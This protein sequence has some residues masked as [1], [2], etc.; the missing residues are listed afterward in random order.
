VLYRKSRGVVRSANALEKLLN[1]QLLEYD[2]QGI[3]LTNAGQAVRLRAL[4]ID[5]ELRKVIDDA[6]YY[7]AQDRGY[8]GNIE[9]LFNERCLQIVSMLAEA[10]HINIVARELGMSHSTASRMIA[11]LEDVLGRA[12]FLSGTHG[13]VVSDVGIR[14][15]ARFNR[16]L[17]ELNHIELDI[18]ALK[19][20]G[21]LTTT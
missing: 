6:V 9:A 7:A 21:R 16:V 20:V 11:N 13:I 17:M 12:L 19:C 15:I 18:A 8:V 14:W 3:M 5:S 10:H 1:I 2:R 4:V